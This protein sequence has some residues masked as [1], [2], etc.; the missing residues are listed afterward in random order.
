[1]VMQHFRCFSF[2]A[3]LFRC[4]IHSLNGADHED[5]REW[6]HASV[7]LNLNARWP[8]GGG[9]YMPTQYEAG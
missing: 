7:I 4:N 9:P 2:I 5:M 8:L 6:R 3:V 1:M